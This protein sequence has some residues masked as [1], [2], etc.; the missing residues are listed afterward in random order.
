MITMMDLTSKILSLSKTDMD[1]LAQA[2]VTFDR[3]KAENLEYLLQVY[4][5]E[6]RPEEYNV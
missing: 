4:T 1:L 5:R 3:A 6:I 2:L